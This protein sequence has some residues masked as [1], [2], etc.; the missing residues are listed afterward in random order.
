MPTVTPKIKLLIKG[1]ALYAEQAAEAMGIS[2]TS[3]RVHR[4]LDETYYCEALAPARFEKVVEDWYRKQDH[5]TQYPPGS[6]LWYR[7]QEPDET[8]GE[9]LHG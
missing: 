9:V 1:T 8:A 6:L 7:K 3:I 5:A 4:C 2:L